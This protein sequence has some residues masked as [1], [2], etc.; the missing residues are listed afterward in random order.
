MNEIELRNP[1]SLSQTAIQKIGMLVV[2]AGLSS[3]PLAVFALDVGQLF[4]DLGNEH[5]KESVILTN[6][7]ITMRFLEELS[8]R[9]QKLEKIPQLSSDPVHQIAADC[10]LRNLIAETN[11][12][13]AI[14]LARAVA[15]LTVKPQNQVYKAQCAR[16]LSELTEPVLHALQTND[17]LHR[18]QL[19][20]D[21]Q[22]I[23]SA[24]EE[25]SQKLAALLAASMQL[26]DWD[27]VMRRIMDLGLVG[28]VLDGGSFGGPPMVQTAPTTEYGRLIIDLCFEH[29]EIPQF[30]AFATLPFKVD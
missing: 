23:C 12:R 1:S 28:Q 20:A 29:S 27:P 10:A 26:P 5:A 6:K 25:K 4:V 11:E 8:D 19:V 3:I 24:F 13:V 9:I 16:V 14:A 15:L 7:K 22:E 21:E 18:N 2:K 17:R 30:G